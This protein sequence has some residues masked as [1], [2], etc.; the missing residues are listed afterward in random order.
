MVRRWLAPEKAK[1]EGAIV[2]GPAQVAFREWAL[3]TPG[4]RP[5]DPLA[6]L[7]GT[8]W[9]TA[10]MANALGHIDPTTGRIT[11]YHVDTAMSGPHG[12]VADRDGAIWFTAN[13]AGYIGKL[14]PSTG[15]IA[16]YRLPSPAARDP[17]TPLF[18]QSGILWF[19]VQGASLVD[20]FSQLI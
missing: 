5:H 14:D 17:H 19:T 3:P 1:P 18:D 10:Q 6:S 20:Y 13:F 15:K 4:S 8:I 2:P 7:D 16:E 9:Y 12:L 11:E